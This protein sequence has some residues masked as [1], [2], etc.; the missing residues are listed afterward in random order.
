MLEN[1][2]NQLGIP[3]PVGSPP[4]WIELVPAGPEV[5]GVDG[6]RWLN[7]RPGQIV[8]AFQQRRRPLVIDWEHAT[9]YRAPQGL[10]A[11]AAGW[12]DRLEVRAGAIWGHVQTWTARARQQ[13]TERAYRYLSPAFLFEKVSSRIVALTSAGLTNTPNL[14]LVAL[15][16]VDLGVQPL[17][18]TTREI[19]RQ[20]G[21]DPAAL[22]QHQ[23]TQQEHAC[24]AAHWD[25]QLSPNQRRICETMGIDPAAF[26]A[27]RYPARRP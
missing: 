22:R 7:D 11:P 27:A 6:R 26:L 20:M 2:Q 16:R 12:V 14:A 17:T 4:D 24:N 1:A 23:R 15:N 21:L 8:T 18:D 25:A 19:A 3:L 10:D 5:V 13:L 9:E